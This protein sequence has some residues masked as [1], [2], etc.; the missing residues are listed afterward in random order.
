[1]AEPTPETPAT[2]PDGQPWNDLVELELDG[3]TYVVD[4]DAI[5]ARDIKALSP[6][7]G[8]ADLITELTTAV[9]PVSVAALL[10]LA[11][12]QARKPIAVDAAFDSVTVRSRF[13]V[14]NLPRATPSTDPGASPE[15]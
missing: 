9:T 11:R 6:Y 1:M 13:G 8:Y 3:T 10:F 14:G 7:I 15:A 2:A 12:R 4:I 5:S